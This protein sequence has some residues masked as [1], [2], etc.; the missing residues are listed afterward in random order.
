MYT[1]GL[2]EINRYPDSAFPVAMYR[3][4]RKGM[5]P[6]GRGIR[7]FHWHEELQFTLLERGSA[8]IRID[9]G[10]YQLK[11]KDA[12][13]INSNTI[14]AVT[15]LSEDGSYASLNFPVSIL[16]FFPGSRMEVEDV[17]PY[18]AANAASALV[19]RA[20]DPAHRDVL[21]RLQEMNEI[22]D[23]TDVPHREYLIS[24]RITALWYELLCT[25]PSTQKDAA[26]TDRV[27]RLRLQAMLTF[28]YEH[29]PEDIL[30]S[31]IAGAANISVGECCRIFR[32]G[33]KTTPHKFLTEY[34]I[35]RSVQVLSD[36]YSV[37]EAARM[38]GYNQTS[39]YIA[40]FKSIM[41]QTPAQYRRE[42][43]QHHKT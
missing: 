15:E 21:F 39:H 31:D 25:L 4:S 9:T 30:L 16:C 32:S 29:Y 28:I 43:L 27:H 11:P 7:D 18:A 13:F 24:C 6:P 36:A 42:V 35:R 8:A 20:D 41:H 2:H 34:R 22:W 26:E 19:L 38:C 5:N 14:H 1:S 40:A 3:V 12:V 17:A 33:L 10:E 37:A 23:K